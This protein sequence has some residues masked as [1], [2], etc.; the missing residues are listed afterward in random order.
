MPATDLCAMSVKRVNKCFIRVS[1]ERARS[2]VAER[3]ERAIG[4][5]DRRNHEDIP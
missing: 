1:H 3:A 2:N 4:I 5:K